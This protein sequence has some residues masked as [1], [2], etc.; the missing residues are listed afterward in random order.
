MKT[1]HSIYM[2]ILCCFF[3]QVHYSMETVCGSS[4]M[5]VM[6][7]L[8]VGGFLVVK[9]SLRQKILSGNQMHAINYLILYIYV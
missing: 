9:A 7:V 6:M 1:S 4:K 5:L 2:V 3:F 8:F